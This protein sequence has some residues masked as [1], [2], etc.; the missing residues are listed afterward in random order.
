MLQIVRAMCSM[1][2]EDAIKNLEENTPE[3]RVEK[4]FALVDTVRS[5]THFKS[6]DNKISGWE[7]RPVK[8]GIHPSGQIGLC[9]R[10]RT[11][12]VR[13]NHLTCEIVLLSLFTDKNLLKIMTF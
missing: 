9:Y 11:F 8:R 2:G 10:Q 5:N 1:F 12:F 13:R 6:F 4:I 3:K 7:R